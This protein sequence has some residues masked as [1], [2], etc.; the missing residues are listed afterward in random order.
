MKQSQRTGSRRRPA[1]TGRPEQN[2]GERLRQL[3]TERNISVRTL[4]MRTGFSA[5]FVSQVELNQASPSISSLERLAGALGVTLGDFFQEPGGASPVAVTR[6]GKRRPL[7]SWWSH[8]QLEAL[9]PTGTRRRLEAVLI[10]IAGGGSSGKRPHPNPRHQ[11]AVVF[12]GEVHLT[13]EKDDQ[14]LTRGDSVTIAASTPHRWQ[15]LTE[16]SAKLIIVSVR[17]TR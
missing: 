14:R 16:N 1:I 8:A 12:Q 13:L 15:N 2:L 5:S 11:F 17:A 4:A 7:T 6:S 10:T 9:T 3:R